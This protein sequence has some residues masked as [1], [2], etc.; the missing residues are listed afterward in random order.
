ML[1]VLFPGL[2]KDIMIKRA[3]GVFLMFFAVIFVVAISQSQYGN[4]NLEVG[5]VAS[6]DIK[7]PYRLE[8]TDTYED[9]VNEALVNM[10]PVYRISPTIQITSK[11]K[12]TGYL[13]LVRD[14]KLRNNLSNVSRI[15]ELQTTGPMSLSSQVD[16]AAIEL[17]FSDLNSI[18]AI[19][20]DILSQLLAQGIRDDELQDQV[21]EIDGIVNV[22]NLEENEEFVI[23]AILKEA[24]EPN[25]FVD[26]IATERQMENVRGSI[27]I[28][29]IE[30]NETI[31]SKGDVVTEE[32]MG[33]VRLA[34]LDDTKN[35]SWLRYMGMGILLLLPLV[36]LMMYIIYFYPSI[37]DGRLI[38]LIFASLLLTILLGKVMAMLSPYLI[39]SALNA[40]LVTM[41]VGSRLAIVTNFLLV[42]ILSFIWDIPSELI[43]IMLI[44]NSAG[45]LLLVHRNQRHRVLLN[46]IYMGIISLALYTGY[47][48][49]GNL[50]SRELIVN[51]G[52]LVISGLLSG[53]VSLGT[54][55]LWE[56]VFKV[57]TPLK[58]MELTDPNQPMLRRLFAE[59]PGTYHHSLIVGNLAESAAATIGANQLLAKAGAYY[60]DIGKLKRPSYFKEN[61]FGNENP[62]DNL[63][64]LQS[65]EIIIS[66]WEDGIK[67][68]K[69]SKLPRE[70]M[71]I[72][73]QH[74]GKTLM[75]YFY[76]KATMGNNDLPEEKFRYGGQKPNSKEATI[77][78]FADSVEA[79][80]RSIKSMNENSIESMV[81]KVIR[82]KIDDGQLDESPITTREINE[83]ANTFIS[84][85]KGIYHERIEYPEN[86]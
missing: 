27:I 39:P 1:R 41:L 56:G 12:V 78:M 8:D 31:I 24:I 79:A 7:A 76:H 15:D 44:G 80:V 71:E 10:E 32:Q 51:G 69:D 4:I 60:H 2:D 49:L 29:V 38:Y 43:A 25:E 46:G 11:A 50:T 30:Q 58:L 19:T 82:G 26:T 6:E 17:T 83:I 35:G 73:D 74:H 45:I 85:L 22:L 5:E 16:Q 53:I 65:T 28:P 14:I 66:H 67:L 21:G 84:V 42:W 37:M 3:M 34:Q 48:L 72:I 20:E 70:I 13:D 9:Q 81:R 47:Y 63:E 62:H 18:E 77:V 23:S 40:I 57:L 54:L 64:P 61:Q 55:P 86:S 33:I 52:F 75:S 68:G 36:A 59:A